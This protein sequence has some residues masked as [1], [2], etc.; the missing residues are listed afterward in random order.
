MYGDY[1]RASTTPVLD[2]VGSIIGVASI[3]IGGYAA[4]FMAI[5]IRDGNTQLAFKNSLFLVVVALVNG[6]LSAVRRWRRRRL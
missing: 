4:L 1:E 3:V 2:A 6:A 5:A